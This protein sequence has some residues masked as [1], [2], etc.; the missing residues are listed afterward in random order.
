MTQNHDIR[1]LADNVANKIAAGEVVERPASVVK[2][3]VENAL[4]AGATRIDIEIAAGGRKL[5]A[6]SD[7][8]SGMNRDNALTAIERHATSKISDVDDIES[9]SSLGFRGEALPAI[10]SVSRFRMVSCNSGNAPGTEILISGGKVKDVRETGAAVGTRI[11]VRNLFFNVPARRKFMRS[12]KTEFSHVKTAF[13]TQAIA[14]PDVAMSLNSDGRRVFQLAPVSVKERLLDLFGRSYMKNLREIPAT[15]GA[16]KVEGL[17]SIP[18]VN[19]PDRN[20]QYVF[21]N[22]RAVKSA[23]ISRC[24]NEAYHGLTPERRHPSVFLF[25]K[26]HPEEVDVN[27]HPTKREVRF[28]EPSQTRD[29]VIAAIRNALHVESSAG[30]PPSHRPEESTGGQAVP[31]ATLAI[32]DMPSVRSFRYPG[33]QTATGENESPGYEDTQKDGSAL[34]SS[35]EQPESDVPWSWCRVLGQVGGLYVILEIEDGL[36]LMDPHASHERVLFEKFMKDTIS[37]SVQSQALLMPET[38]NLKP[39]DA[40]QVKRNLDL[41]RQ[42]GFGIDEFGEDTFVIDSL[43]SY[44]S[45]ASPEKML[46]EIASTLDTA[47]KRGGDERWREEAIAQAACKAAVKARDRLTLTEIEQLVVDL[48]GAEMPY[49]CP[50]GRPTLI[51]TSYRELNRK[52]G[53]T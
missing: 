24:I 28:R 48:A 44:F 37:G 8:G 27:V 47:G 2:E 40:R 49:T 1:I 21:V 3:L 25:I 7:N 15:S 34:R 22:G 41:F 30:L 10:A 45:S 46:V 35:E 17:V 53:R 33:L 50:H 6:V 39:G 31:D 29:T 36:V 5:V 52:F 42:M 38:V 51:L 20:E 4:D 9:I 19:R 16:V 32:E 13:I 23:L 14:N 43:P 18:T 26:V 12:H 11:E